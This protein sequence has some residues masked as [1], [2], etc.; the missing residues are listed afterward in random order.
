MQKARTVTADAGAKLWRRV[1]SFDERPVYALL[2][3]GKNLEAAQV[4]DVGL[5]AHSVACS[6]VFF[7]G[8]GLASWYTHV[9]AC[10]AF[11]ASIKL[12]ASDQE[13]G[14]STDLS[15]HCGCGGV[16]FRV[17]RES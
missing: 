7:R 1:P 8:E 11:I 10:I 5:K 15:R 6:F 17:I 9:A 16:R 14:G 4:F 12:K 13:G 3:K 2:Q